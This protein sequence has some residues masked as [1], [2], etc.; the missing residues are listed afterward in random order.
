MPETLAAGA[1]LLDRYRLEAPLASRLSSS[2]AWLAEDPQSGARVEVHL[3]AGTP[4]RER[5]FPPVRAVMEKLAAAPSRAIAR[6]LRLEWGEDGRLVLVLEYHDG[7]ALSTLLA[8]RPTRPDEAREVL[9]GLLHALAH[10]TRAG[11]AHGRLTPA[12]V[13]LGAENQVALLDLGIAPLLD[14]A[15]AEAP[16]RAPGEARGARADAFAVAV[17]AYELLSAKRPE[18]G[19][20]LP[21]ISP[22]MSAAVGKPFL[23]AI[24]RLARA[25]GSATVFDAGALLGLLPARRSRGRRGR[26]GLSEVWDGDIGSGTARLMKLA[27]APEYQGRMPEEIRGNAVDADDGDGPD[28]LKFLT[29][30]P[31]VFPRTPPP[32]QPKPPDPPKPVDPPKPAL[33]KT[34]PPSDVQSVSGTPTIVR[35]V[36]LPRGQPRPVVDPEATI[37]EKPPTISIKVTPAAPKGTAGPLLLKVGAEQ[38]AFVIGAPER[39]TVGRERGNHLVLRA[40]KGTEVDG[41]DSNRISRHHLTLTRTANGFQAVDEKSTYGTAVDATRL[42]PGEPL[43]LPQS[44]F[45]LHLAGSAL[46]LRCRGFAGSGALRLAREDRTGHQYLVLMGGPGTAVRVGSSA[47]E[48]ALLV[49]GAKRGHAFLR[50]DP[51]TQAIQ[52]TPAEGPVSVNG[53][54]LA[55]GSWADVHPGPIE[56]GGVKLAAR[57]LNAPYDFFA[58]AAALGL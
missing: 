24:E 17:I 8:A 49:E 32:S 13:L 14:P 27:I 40:F 9:R 22:E 15:E 48:D 47:D 20:A 46:G 57:A 4:E 10:A 37:V 53:V 50:I 16:W 6:P 39:V 3:L 52:V 54:N 21:P 55:K 38:V 41:V 1:L 31:G 26:Y 33:E 51:A 7:R 28:E 58:G 35:T 30:L 43:A 19:R 23:E 56:L 12:R 29:T 2:E 36:V 34:L 25:D 5:A 11:V 45:M 44:G 18:R 42:K